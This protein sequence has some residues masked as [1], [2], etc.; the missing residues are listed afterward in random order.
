MDVTAALSNAVGIANGMT[1]IIVAVTSLVL[2]PLMYLY[3]KVIG[4]IPP[5]VEY[6]KD[7]K[8][9]ALQEFALQLLRSRDGKTRGLQRK[10][11]LQQISSELM[12]AASHTSGKPDSDDES[13]DDEEKVVR[14]SEVGDGGRGKK[15]GPARRSSAS[16]SRVGRESESRVGRE[17]ES[18]VGR[19]SESRVGRESE[20]RVGRESESVGGQPM[21][22]QRNTAA[23]S[24]ATANPNPGSIDSNQK[25]PAKTTLSRRSSLVF[26]RP[27]GPNPTSSSSNS[28]S[29]SSSSSSSS[30]SN[31]SSMV[32]VN[33]PM[34]SIKDGVEL[35]RLPPPA[36]VAS[37]VIPIGATP[38]PLNILNKQA[39]SRVVKKQLLSIDG[40]HQF[41]SSLNNELE[42]LNSLSG[43][44]RT[45]LLK[46][47]EQKAER[48][49]DVDLEACDESDDRSVFYALQSLL[50]KHGSFVLSCPI[51]SVGNR[52]AYIVGDRVFYPYELQELG[53]IGDTLP[54]EGGR[55][56]NS[57]STYSL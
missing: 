1:S 34:N 27:T 18:R 24:V 40:M 21:P 45:I 26:A 3:L 33:N 30:S 11:V 41:V 8:D 36:R 53:S 14:R 4:F 22:R 38:P 44:D 54:S 19:E 15:K 51:T 13:S 23:K 7:E 2:L 28:R 47:F 52:V 16:A 12:Y 29:K 57:I 39:L 5:K 37:P 17:S 9:L 31:A 49:R 32:F 43:Q 55:G 42:A 50:V 10:G 48:L 25:L 46:Q 20:S 56:I 6:E 35:T